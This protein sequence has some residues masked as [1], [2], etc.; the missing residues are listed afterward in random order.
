[1][2]ERY[3]VGVRVLP[4]EQCDHPWFLCGFG[5]ITPVRQEPRP[6][7]SQVSDAEESV[8]WP[9]NLATGLGA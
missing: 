8:P 5:N 1:M 4:P 9:A 2:P 7:G 3:Y 6:L